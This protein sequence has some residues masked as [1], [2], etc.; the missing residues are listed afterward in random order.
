MMQALAVNCD[1]LGG[2]RMDDKK[3]VL[4]AELDFNYGEQFQCIES[5]PQCTSTSFKQHDS[6]GASLGRSKSNQKY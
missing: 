2:T 4:N 6:I 1:I 5:T 3:S